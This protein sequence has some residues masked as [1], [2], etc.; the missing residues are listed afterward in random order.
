M[1]PAEIKAGSPR[2]AARP[3]HRRR[4]AGVS[5]CEPGSR[6]AGRAVG[7]R[8]ATAGS[9][10]RTRF[11]E[12][13]R[14]ARR[15]RNR[16][17]A[18]TRAPA[19][20][21]KRRRGE[22]SPLRQ[23]VEQGRRH[24]SQARRHP[25]GRAS[26]GHEVRQ[27][28]VGEGTGDGAETVPTPPMTSPTTRKIE[29][30][31]PTGHGRERP[32]HHQHARRCLRTRRSRRIH[33]PVQ[34][35][36]HTAGGGALGPSRTTMIAARGGHLRS[37]GRAEKTAAITIDAV[38]PKRSARRPA[39]ANGSQHGGPARPRPRAVPF[40]PPVSQSEPST[41]TRKTFAIASVTT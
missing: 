2:P 31:V 8:L 21:R 32:V 22:R 24:L 26:T 39:S 19:G 25:G 17:G 16:P 7:R 33:R 38:Q 29:T 35:H 14:H 40:G 4:P 36:V 18:R 1:N 30:F 28:E 41:D 12:P 13:E 27:E 20:R 34:R 5:S 23:R 11:V 3:A 10:R 37:C 15:R 9:G 6:C